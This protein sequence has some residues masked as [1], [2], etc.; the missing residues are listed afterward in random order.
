MDTCDQC[1]RKAELFHNE[2]AGLA[3]CD[4][5]D[6]AADLADF[7]DDQSVVTEARANV[8]LMERETAGLRVTLTWRPERDDC[9]LALDMAGVCTDRAV[10]LES[11]MDA[12]H[13]P[14]LYL[15]PACV[16]ELGIR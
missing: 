16:A 10:P 4:P 11:A 3:L 14:M 12:F 8:E 13:H 9:L 15:A 2:Q 5:C 7:R 1:G 6:M